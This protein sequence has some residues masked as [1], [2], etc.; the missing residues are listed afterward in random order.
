VG[1]G[2]ALSAHAVPAIEKHT[3]KRPNAPSEASP[4]QRT[5][6]RR[7]ALAMGLIA[8]AVY[9]AFVLSGVIGR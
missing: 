3:M 9:V 7:T 4:Q 5:A 6:A 8:L 1:R 2:L